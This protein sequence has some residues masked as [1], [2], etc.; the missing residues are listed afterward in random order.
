MQVWQYLL[1]CALG[2][3]ILFFVVWSAACKRRRRKERDFTR[4]LET[5]LQ[6]RENV[7][8]VCPN[9]GGRWVLTSKRLLMEDGD[10]FFA[11]PFSKLKRV[12]GQDANGKTTTSPAKMARLIVNGEYT[13]HNTCEEFLEF[14]KQLKTRVK[15]P[16]KT[17]KG[18]AKCQ[19]GK[20]QPS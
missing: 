7:K 18:A 19:E 11:I 14:A 15:K 13:L 1:L 2:A 12:Q 16:K 4:R 9:R 17:A 10:G 5:V 20:K 6:P 3:L 8:L